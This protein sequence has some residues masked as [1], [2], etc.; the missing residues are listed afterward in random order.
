MARRNALELSAMT[1]GK[2]HGMQR[3]THGKGTFS[4]LELDD[5]HA[6]SQRLQAA[7]ARRGEAREVTH[8]EAVDATL[9]LVHALGRKCTG[10]VLGPACGAWHAV[11]AFKLPPHVGH[12]VR[13]GRLTPEPTTDGTGRVTVVEPGWSVAKIKRLGADAVKLRVPYEPEHAPSAQRQRDLI[14][15][16]AADCDRHDIALLLATYSYPLDGEHVTSPSYLERRPRTVVETARHLSGLCDV[17]AAEFPGTRGLESHERLAANLD[18]L[19]EACRRPWGLRDGGTDFAACEAEL[20]LALDHGASGALAGA[21]VWEPFAEGDAGQRAAFLR[22]D[23]AQRIATVDRLAKQGG[24]PWFKKYRLTRGRFARVQIPQDW[25]H[26]Y[27]DGA[28]AVP[29]AALERP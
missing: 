8:D 14:E 21:A 27:P 19:D 24:K 3:I 6:V 26:D 15:Q 13:L 28:P 17:Y 1:P 9:S 20:A 25:H 11:C 5:G 22:T 16:V 10:I 4:L 7:L 18:A 12:I 23:G 29:L 2:L